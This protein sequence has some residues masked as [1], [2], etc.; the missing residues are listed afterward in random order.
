[1]EFWKTILGLLRRKSVAV[2]VVGIAIAAAAVVFLIVPAR[3]ISSSTMVLTIPTAGGTLSQDA[4][5]PNGLTNPLLNFD[6]GLKTTSVILI[7]AMNTPEV[8]SDLGVATGPSKLTVDDG[9]TNPQL[10]DSN[11]PFL[12]VVGESDTAAA[13]Q[14]LVVRAQARIRQ[15]LV[16][17]QRALGAPEVT[18]IS[19]VD[20]VSPTVPE[21]THANQ[22]KYAG[23]AFAVTLA[24]GLSLAYFLL[25]RRERGIRSGLVGDLATPDGRYSTVASLP[26]LADA[27]PIDG[28]YRRRAIAPRRSGASSTGVGGTSGAGS[29]GPR[30]TRAGQGVQPQRPFGMRRPDTSGSGARSQM[31]PVDSADTVDAPDKL[32]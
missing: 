8:A 32:A 16:D 29:L 3:Y 14:D 6:D 22:I 15:E 30:E 26:S 17:R 27:A 2:P 11:G 24:S 25:R 23:F 18:Y 7:E 1:M 19:V 28:M 13:A 5:R 12:Y 4:S 10:L 9:T 21:M 20:V 31:N